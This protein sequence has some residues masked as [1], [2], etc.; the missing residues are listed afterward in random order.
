MINKQKMWFITLFTL[1]LVLSVYYITMPNDILD[2]TNI[3]NI[4]VINTSAIDVLKESKNEEYEKDLKDLEETIA[5]VNTTTDEKNIAYE[6]L[7]IKKKEKITTEELE[8]KI[9]NN[10]RLDSV[11]S[12]ESDK[13]KV[14]LTSTDNSYTLANDIIRTIQEEFDVEKEIVVK[15]K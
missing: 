2:V 13:I 1:I 11:V 12:F 8:N 15:F 10:F 5:D 3:D 14:I 4:E 9:K 7:N 6:M